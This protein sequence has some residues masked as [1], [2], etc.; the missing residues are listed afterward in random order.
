[1]KKLKIENIKITELAEYENN[2]K[3]HT[4]EQ[5]EHIKQSIME[6][7]NNDPIAIWKD[8]TIIEG[9]GRLQALKE[10]GYKTVPV[11]RLDDLT[12]TQ[13][14][15]YIIVHNKLTLNS[16]LDIELLNKE[17]SEIT[18]IDM[19]KYGLEITD[20]PTQDFYTDL[21]VD[22]PEKEKE[23]IRCPYCGEYFDAE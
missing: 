2:S 20:I 9:H 12:D 4:E 21:F 1:M 18:E 23:Q 7:G 11:I 3:R 16:S 14:K 5:I 15:A 13:R 19:E 6:F 22:A 8:N 10:L 17:L